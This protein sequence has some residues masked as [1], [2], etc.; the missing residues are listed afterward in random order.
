MNKTTIKIEGMACGMCEAHINDCIRKTI[1]GAKKVSASWKKG[2]AGFLTE[3]AVDLEALKA[4]VNATGYTVISAET[5]P[6]V[7]RGLFG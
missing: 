6:Y 3:G 7:K 2:E 4:A 5:E 1:P